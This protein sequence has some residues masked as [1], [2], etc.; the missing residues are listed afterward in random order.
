MFGKLHWYEF[1][2]LLIIFLVIVYIS[3]SKYVCKKCKR[4]NPA[5][6]SA[7]PMSRFSA[8]F[9]TS[10]M[11]SLRH[12]SVPAGEQIPKNLTLKTH[13]PTLCFPLCHNKFVC[14]SHGISLPAL[15]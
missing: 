2:V 13:F 8:S 11:A 7:P 5:R 15:K 6:A 14:V 3:V 12:C 4:D 10:P 9:P 1:S